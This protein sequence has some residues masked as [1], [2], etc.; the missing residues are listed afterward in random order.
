M[1]SAPLLAPAED[2]N[3][4]GGARAGLEFPASNG[5]A[6]QAADS[7]SSRGQPSALTDD[8]SGQGTGIVCIPYCFGSWCCWE[9]CDCGC[10][11]PETVFSGKT[12]Y[13]L[14]EGES[15]LPTPPLPPRV[16]SQKN[17][18][19]HPEWEGG[20]SILG[21]SL[22]QLP[23]ANAHDSSDSIDWEAV[24]KAVS[25]YLRAHEPSGAADDD[26][27]ESAS[28]P[29]KEWPDCVY[30]GQRVLETYT[31][32]GDAVI[33]PL[34]CEK[35]SIRQW[36]QPCVTHRNQT[37]VER[38]KA[39]PGHEAPRTSV[40]A[41]LFDKA[42]VEKFV[43]S[44]VGVARRTDGR[45]VAYARPLYVTRTGEYRV[46]VV[47]DRLLSD[48]A[49]ELMNRKLRR[50]PTLKVRQKTVTGDDFLRFLRK[51]RREGRA[52]TISWSH[53]WAKLPEEPCRYLTA[54]GGVSVP[55]QPV[56]QTQGPDYYHEWRKQGEPGTLEA[57][58]L[59]VRD[60][61]Q[62]LPDQSK[63][64]EWG[65]G[66]RYRARAAVRK[67][68]AET[69]CTGN[70]KYLLH[71][72]EAYTG[73]RAMR[74]CYRPLLEGWKPEPGWFDG[75]AGE[76]PDDDWLWDDY[77]EVL[78]PGVGISGEAVGAAGADETGVPC[79]V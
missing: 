10:H 35:L 42:D 53:N 46:M 16:F 70:W 61:T 31:P 47:F 79:H 34:T 65:S 51:V 24:W 17:G 67:W 37:R 13:G 26:D 23:P 8:G 75:P 71:A 7:D 11:D 28:I 5:P 66:P 52:N 41:T 45:D 69:R 59:W 6:D 14:S 9:V 1:S 3:H 60:H 76:Y 22:A 62:E 55:E 63:L 43:E 15:T 44:F 12:P 78:S 39:Q 29:E 33:I 73:L 58:K 2:S 36:C 72:A 56:K 49:H 38:Y 27:S 68:M 50:W 25:E 54:G 20:T 32:L 18:N 64:V 40:V 74:K 21:S 48:R 4:L 77:F 30:R 19:A 57:C